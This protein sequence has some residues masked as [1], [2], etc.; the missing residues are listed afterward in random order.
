MSQTS[1][2]EDAAKERSSS[3]MR[4][5]IFSGEYNALAL[6]CGK[7]EIMIEFINISFIYLIGIEIE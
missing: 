5:V 4:Y 1:V 3:C 7:R 6:K 2:R